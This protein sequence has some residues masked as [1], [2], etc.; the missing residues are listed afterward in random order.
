MPSILLLLEVQGHMTKSQKMSTKSHLVLG[1]SLKDPV[2]L[3]N[4]LMRTVWDMANSHFE[5]RTT[6]AMRKSKT[7]NARYLNENLCQIF[8]Y[9][10]TSR[11]SLLSRP[12]LTD[13]FKTKLYFESL[14]YPAIY[15]IYHYYI[16]TECKEAG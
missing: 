4:H 6:W 2:Y 5:N 14:C 11:Y 3:W 12:S 13:S 9:F 1:Y 16:P 10:Q 15:F 7:D 8:R